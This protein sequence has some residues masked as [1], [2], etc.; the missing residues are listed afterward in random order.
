MID[1]EIAA[2]RAENEWLRAIVSEWYVSDDSNEATAHPWWMIVDPRRIRKS[3]AHDIGYP[4]NMITGPFP[5]RQAAEDH[6]QAQRYNFGPHAGV[7]CHSA[8]PCP[9]FR[10]LLAA[11]RK[12]KG[13][14]P[15]G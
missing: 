12:L 4:A 11:A 1:E 2:L 5:S 13:E 10:R 7:W 15:L 3:E 9:A 6:L 14:K 8:Y